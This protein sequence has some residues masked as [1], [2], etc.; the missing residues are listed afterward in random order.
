MLNYI[1]GARWSL[2][3]V[4]GAN[5]IYSGMIAIIIALVSMNTRTSEGSRDPS[6]RFSLIFRKQQGLIA[7][8][9]SLF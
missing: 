7:H 1:A 2:G 8:P 5:W 9:D 3:L 6:L 4:R